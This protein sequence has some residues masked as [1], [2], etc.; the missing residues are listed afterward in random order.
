MGGGGGGRVQHCNTSLP[1]ITTVIC[2]VCKHLHLTRR[3]R[4]TLHVHNI[5]II[6]QTIYYYAVYK[7]HYSSAD[8]IITKMHI[9]I[10]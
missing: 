2:S 3:R 8:N 5:I 9:V 4:H 1:A 10:L 7:Q 6:I